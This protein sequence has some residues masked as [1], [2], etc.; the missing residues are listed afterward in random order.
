MNQVRQLRE[1]KRGGGVA[2]CSSSAVCSVQCADLMLTIRWSCRF[3]LRFC[4][5]V[6][7]SEGKTTCT[8]INVC[9]NVSDAK[10]ASLGFPMEVDLKE[11]IRDYIN[12]YI[13]TK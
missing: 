5:Q 7:A 4:P 1:S 8:E 9:P 12:R 2:H 3:C 6:A 13:K 10:A 11:I